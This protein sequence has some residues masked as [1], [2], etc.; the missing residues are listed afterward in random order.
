[1][2][3]TISLICKKKLPE[4][5]TKIFCL[6]VLILISVIPC[7]LNSQVTDEDKKVVDTTAVKEQDSIK[8]AE[9][10]SSTKI[11]V[12]VDSI[13]S[14]DSL[15]LLELNKQLD[16]L[17]TTDNIKKEEILEQLSD[18][19]KADSLKKIERKNRIDSL[20]LITTGYPVIPFRDT[21][22]IVY[23]KLGPFSAKDRAVTIQNKIK[24]L[25]E[26]PDFDVNSFQ[27]FKG[28]QSHDLMYNDIVILSMTDN[29]A[30]WLNKTRD[31]AVIEYQQKVGTSIE[32]YIEENSLKNTLMRI[33]FA[34]LTIVGLFLILKYTN[35]L[36]KFIQ[37]KIDLHKAKYFKGIK[38][39]GYE[40]LNHER[41]IKVVY[42][43]LKFLKVV[44]FLVLTYIFLAIL[45]G[46]FPSTKVIADTLLRYILNPV[47]K[48][49]KAF[50]GFLP[51]LLTIIVVVVI[52][53]YILKFVR[54]LSSEIEE[55]S[56]SL[57]GF[58]ADWAKPTYNIVRV[59]ILAFM[60][61]V[62]F[63][64]LP[65]SDSPIFQGVTVFLALLFSLG[66]TTAVANMVAGLV[67]TYMR[68]FK[69]G[70][71]VKIGDVVGDVIEK[72]MLVTR[73]RTI[74]NEDIT[75]PNANVMSNHTINYSSSAQDIGLIMHTT[76]TIGYDVPWKT[77]HEILINASL[78]TN[79]LLK[80]PKPFVL[81]TSLDDFYVSYQLNA[82]TH[83]PSRQAVIYSELHQNIQNKFNEAGVE[84]MS[85]HYRGM[86]D[87]NLTAIPNDYLPE[88]YI[89][90][91][92]RI[93]N[94]DKNK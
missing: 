75:I 5:K 10:Q 19:K 32:N 61:I 27:I 46:I 51:N 89:T 45:F 72:S 84:I 81:Q 41:E 91:S 9:L 42:A 58:Y 86:R 43:L 70:D 26:T 31:E 78:D 21:L 60:F 47:G 66:S 88:N 94:T 34:L 74:K 36:F 44:L 90:P 18:L 11:L 38:I 23:A 80:E 79:G 73:I 7:V 49:W 55:G 65:G 14:V 92:F 22:F 6:V 4:M 63:P 76:V 39:K 77:V 17:K 24:V 2:Q 29:D 37:Q 82:Y 69:I 20:R 50:T 3:N 93:Q 64:Y 15:K 16:E 53:R 71:R 30:L 25:A 59:L 33:G 35:K 87:G 68:P 1:M 54:F 83:E 48:M 56:L 13:R 85:P 52:T 62:I 12:R 8:N 57:P 40:L 28:E 67:I